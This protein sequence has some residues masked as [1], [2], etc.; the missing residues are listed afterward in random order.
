MKR[1]FILLS[2]AFLTV[3]TAVSCKD[4]NKENDPLRSTTWSA[5]D[6]DNLMVLKF[7]LGTIATFYIGNSNLE[8]VGAASVSPYTLTDNTR[9]SFTDLNGSYENERYR[10]KTGTLDGDAM[11]IRYD[12]WT[13][14]G[15]HDGEK[16][17]K[18]AVFRKKT[19]PKKK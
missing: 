5:Y 13:F 19:E 15:G 9:I 17:H 11:E 18:Q 1:T 12:R 2:L 6:G 14:A 4:K 10:F 3:L 8:R 16:E 7:D